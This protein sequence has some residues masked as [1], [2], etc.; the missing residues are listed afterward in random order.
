MCLAGSQSCLCAHRS[1]VDASTLVE[2]RGA[3]MVR[4]GRRMADDIGSCA[5][6]LEHVD[7][8]TLAVANKRHCDAL[9]NPLTSFRWDGILREGSSPVG[10]FETLA[11]SNTTLAENSECH[12]RGV[13][14]MPSDTA[15][16]GMIL[17]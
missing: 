17:I 15:A 4:R 9:R 3:A 8:S 6:C 16:R 1:A 2:G 5:D 13:P 10:L 7:L 14:G 11:S 12:K